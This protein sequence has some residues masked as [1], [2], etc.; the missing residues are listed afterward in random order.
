[1]RFARFAVRWESCESIKSEEGKVEIFY[2]VDTQ[3]FLT[4]INL[5]INVHILSHAHVGDQPVERRS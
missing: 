1:M 3:F 4:V 2:T 5:N